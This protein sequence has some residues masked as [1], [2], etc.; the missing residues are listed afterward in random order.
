M[1]KKLFHKLLIIAGLILLMSIALLMIQSTIDERLSFHE[2]AVRSVGNDSARQQ[3]VIGPVLVLPYREELEVAGDKNSDDK[4][5]VRTASHVKLV[6]PN[7]LQLKGRMNTERRYRGI[8]QVLLY[9]GQHGLSGDFSLPALNDVSRNWA[10]SRVVL[11]R[12]YV[13]LAVSDVRGIRDIPHLNWGGRDLEFEQGAGLPGHSSGMHAALSLADWKEGDKI[14][15]SFTL[16][17]SGLEHQSFVPVAKNNSFAIAS[18]WP[19]PQFGGDFLPESRTITDEGFNAS[20]RIS[21]M[22]SS[23]QQQLTAEANGEK[24]T[25]PQAFDIGFIE[26]VN[27]YSQASRANKYGLLFVVLTFGAFFV[28]EIL[29][30]LTIHPVQ[31]L[32]VGLALALFFLLLVGLSEHISFVVA[33]VISSAA[34]IVLIGYYLGHVL[35]RFWRG[36]G[37]GAGLSLLY[38][39]LYGLLVSENNALVLGSLLLFAILAAV[40]IATRKVN[41]YEIGN[42]AA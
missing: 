23:A 34:C 37:F 8:H 9:S 19:H 2:E 35:H 38:G 20:W 10:A 18:N 3:M 30:A 41:W 22:A 24:A 25:A 36:A 29:K 1:Q 7:E 21:A 5:T 6:F 33:Y 42:S 11:G 15:F 14:K 27:I 28:Y 39:A 13:A 26:P 32:L 31:Y 40:M 17:L 12:P 4:P 16:N